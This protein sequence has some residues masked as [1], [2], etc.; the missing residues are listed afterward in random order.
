MQEKTVTYGF[1]VR[2]LGKSTDF[3]WRKEKIMV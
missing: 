1:A 3:I 2:Y